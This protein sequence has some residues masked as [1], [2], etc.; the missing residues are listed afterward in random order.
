M[1]SQRLRFVVALKDV[2]AEQSIPVHL[3]TPQAASGMKHVQRLSQA[4]MALDECRC[5]LWHSGPESNVNMEA[6]GTTLCMHLH[7]GDGSYM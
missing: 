6:S 5:C 3:D 4:S 2:R 7:C 1:S